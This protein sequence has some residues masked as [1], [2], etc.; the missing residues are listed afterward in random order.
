MS[1]LSKVFVVLVFVV[2]LFKLGVDATLFAQRVDWKDK[3][4]KEVNYHYQTQHIKNA[5]ISD[6]NVQVESLNNYNQKLKEKIDALDNE[7]A[8][9]ATRLA[10][11]G[12]DMDSLQANYQK[13]T[14]TLEVQVR[15][16]DVQL[17]QI[18]EMTNKVEDYRTRLGKANTEK[19]TAVQELQYVRQEAER[20]SKDLAG[21]ED[22][23]QALARE[24]LRTK[25][26][27][28]ELNK[29][30]VQTDLVTPSRV[31]EAKVTAVDA[32]IGLVI[33]SIGRDDGVLEG[34]EFT[35]YRGSNFVAKIVVD[36]VDRKWSAARVTLK[37]EDPRVSD[38]VSNNVLTSQFK[39]SGN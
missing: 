31:L 27:I 25:E 23:H 19:L 2:A 22:S 9:L 13:L 26:I 15:Q 5:E 39:A 14:A 1:T 24:H 7:R 10:S 38:D 30:G 29:R 21:L 18:Q 12:R 28:A 11:Q 32:N 8:S 33:V 34:N 36:K 37:K 3:F 4:V 6:L 16:L 17:T 20:L 35:I